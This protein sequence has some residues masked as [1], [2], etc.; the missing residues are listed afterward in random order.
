VSAIHRLSLEFRSVVVIFMA[1]SLI[2]PAA[3]QAGGKPLFRVQDKEYTFEDISGSTEEKVRQRLMEQ[4]GKMKLEQLAPVLSNESRKEIGDLPESQRLMRA[5][6][7]VWQ[8]VYRQILRPSVHLIVRAAIADA[9]V[10]EHGIG[11]DEYFDIEAIRIAIRKQNRL[12]DALL[13]SP[14]S[15]EEDQKVYEQLT[16]EHGV[17][18]TKEEWIK[19][20]E[21]VRTS[22]PAHRWERE[23]A[24]HSPIYE[25]IAVRSVLAHALIKNACNKGMYNSKGRDIVEFEKSVFTVYNIDRC[26]ADP[27][28]LVGFFKSITRDEAVPPEKVVALVDGLKSVAPN[29]QVR[30]EF[31]F[32]DTLLD[33]ATLPPIAEVINLKPGSFRFISYAKRYDLTQLDKEAQENVDTDIKIR[34]FIAGAADY[35]PSVELESK[36]LFYNQ[37]FAMGTLKEDG[38]F[39]IA[40]AVGPVNYVKKPY[41]AEPFESA[42]HARKLLS[43]AEVKAAEFRLSKNR[44]GIE[45]LIKMLAGES[46]KPAPKGI[47]QRYA[48]KAE[49]LKKA[50]KL[51]GVPDE[52]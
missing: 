30:A 15:P 51:F 18:M 28:A 6:E 29:T 22:H 34:A 46:A 42:L 44:M 7:V 49:E 10:K 52:L 33:H 37:A 12:V 35:Y 16:Q 27:A 21:E 36:D 43:N 8:V 50:L 4:I 9:I 25:E 32:G 14:D 13:T 47:Q 2:Q 38:L 39:Y 26:A 11:A 20:R 24:R 23:F 3:V 17:K 1:L 5:R 41:P 45:K 19:E 40:N 48:A 31:K